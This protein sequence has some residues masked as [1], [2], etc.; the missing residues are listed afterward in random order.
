M[1]RM[2]EAAL[3]ACG[4]EAGAQGVRVVSRRFGI[5]DV[6]EARLLE[7]PDGLVGFPD[8]R[9]FA[10]LDHR[11]GSPFGWLLSLR[12]PELGFAVAD[13]VRVVPGYEAPR[14]AAAKALGIAPRDVEIVA[15]VAIPGDARRMTIDLRAPIVIDR[16]RRAARQL[17][18][19]DTG[20][21]AAH[22][23]LRRG[24]GCEI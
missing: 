13:P 21:A 14:A 7:F 15:L 10:L 23:I 12:D 1:R 2:A 6:P 4:C 5:L 8:H 3:E 24:L 17:A 9:R 18:L 16:G 22:P 11:P 19:G 20:L